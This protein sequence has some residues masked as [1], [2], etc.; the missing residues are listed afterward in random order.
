M[1]ITEVRSSTFVADLVNF[2]RDKFN[3]NITDP[4]SSSRAANDRFVLTEYP[5]RAVKY[6]VIT[7][8]D[9]GTRQEARLG[10]QAEGTVLRLGI[11]IRIWA[12]N[13]VERDELFDEVY[14]W[15]RTNQFGGSDATTD[16]GIHD[17]NMTSVVNV[18]EADVKS[19]IIEVKYLFIAE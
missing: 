6:P 1:T 4:I 11:E 15:L 13:V 16:A 12:R 3:D 19:K 10:F 18:S 9:T 7:I 14:T 17:F 2:L 5:R 8:T